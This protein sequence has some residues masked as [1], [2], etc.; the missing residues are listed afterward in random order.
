LDFGTSEEFQFSDWDDRERY[1][2]TGD[3]AANL[4][5]E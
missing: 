5:V 2:A 4:I 3:E 1:D